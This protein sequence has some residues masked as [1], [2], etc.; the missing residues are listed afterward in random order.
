MMSPITA[1]RAAEC[2][3]SKFT[4]PMSVPV[5]PL[6]IPAFARPMIVMKR[7]IPTETAFLIEFGIDFIIASRIPTIERMIKRTPSSKTAVSASCHEQPMPRT[8]E[9][10]KNAFNPRPGASATGRLATNAM[11]SVAIADEMAV[12]V[13]TLLHTIP[14]PSARILGFRARMYAIARKVV[15]PATISRLTVEPRSLILNI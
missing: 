2:W 10:V 9:Y 6:T 8:T 12:A 3:R 1:T 11:T 7:P 15:I 13:K 14:V 4:K 5:S